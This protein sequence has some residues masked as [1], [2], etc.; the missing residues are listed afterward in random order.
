MPKAKTFVPCPHAEAIQFCPLYVAA[1][2]PGLLTCC[3]GDLESDYG[4]H[5]A[6]ERREMDFHH[7]VETVRAANPMLVAQCEFGKM[8][9]DAKAQHNRNIRLNGVH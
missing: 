3:D 7:A 5:C 6:V 4:N 1:H 9:A 2:A 8:A